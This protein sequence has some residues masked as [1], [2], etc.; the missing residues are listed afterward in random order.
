PPIPPPRRPGADGGGASPPT[1]GR[2]SGVLLVGTDLDDH[3][4]WA[5]GVALGAER[6]VHLPG[7][8]ES[9]IAAVADAVGRV[10]PPAADPAR[11]LGL[12]LAGE[13]PREPGLAAGEPGEPPGVSP[14]GPLALFC[15]DFP[16]R[17]SPVR[18]RGPTRHPGRGA[19]PDGRRSRR[20]HRDHPGAPGAEGPVRR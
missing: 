12:P 14:G 15:D 16:R 2:R 8:E 10:G 3:T 18:G 17:L 1:P 7:D 5:R 19:P 11:S 9:V 20:R 13:P 4:V 6:V